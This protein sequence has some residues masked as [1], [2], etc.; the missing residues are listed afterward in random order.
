M[1]EAHWLVQ[2]RLD[3]RFTKNSVKHLLELVVCGCFIWKGSGALEW[4]KK[5]EMMN[6]P[7]YSRILD[8]KLELF[9]KQHRTT[10]FLQDWAPCHKSNIV[11]SWF[12]KRPTSG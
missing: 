4:L 10:D 8:E 12:R 9:M 5:R 6:G 7:R 3:P 1:W 11:S 2:Y